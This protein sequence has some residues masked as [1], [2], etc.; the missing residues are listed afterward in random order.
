MGN[1]VKDECGCVITRKYASD[2]L[3]KRVYD[4]P[5]G[6]EIATVRIDESRWFK[7]FYDGEKITYKSSECPVTIITL[8]ALCEAFEEKKDPKEFLN[9]IK[10]FT[11]NDIAKKVMEQFLGVINEK[12]GL[13]S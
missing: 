9:S 8:E 12:S 6:K 2:F 7:L 5:K 3:I 4:K 13:H 11:L 1:M 10:G